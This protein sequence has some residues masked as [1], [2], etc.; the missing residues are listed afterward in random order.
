MV[1]NSCDTYQKQGLGSEKNEDPCKIIDTK[2]IGILKG[3]SA[4]F[5]NLTYKLY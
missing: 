3:L 4:E 2:E 5:K 1:D